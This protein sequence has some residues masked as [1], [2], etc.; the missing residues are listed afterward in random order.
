M[1]DYLKYRDQMGNFDVL[2]CENR[3]WFYRF[4]GHTA[5][6]YKNNAGQLMVLE[7]T[8]LNK[9][10]GI[11]GVQLTPL[12]LWLQ[13]YNGKVYWRKWVWNTETR[14]DCAYA[15]EIFTRFIKE[16]RGTSYP[17]GHKGA[18]LLFKAWWDSPFFKKFSKN[19][20]TTVVIFC[21]HLVGLLFEAVRFTKICTKHIKITHVTPSELIPKDFRE[22]E[23]IDR[24]KRNMG[25]LAPEILIKG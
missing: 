11:K 3:N 23:Y 15:E 5:V 1:N 25:H 17:S 7:S 21:S 2:C 9:F 22:G 6:I 8:S 12:G 14:L 20:P 4:I 24:V 10:S 18:W 19:A 13:Y 16:H